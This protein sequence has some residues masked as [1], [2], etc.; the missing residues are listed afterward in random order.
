MNQVAVVTGSSRGIG[1]AIALQLA[2]DGFRVVV[3][4]NHNEEQAVEVLKT[5]ESAGG[6]GLVVRADVSN[7]AQA[8]ALIEK[9]V[10]EFGQVDVLVNN[11]GINKDALVLRMSDE[12]WNR[13]INTN[14]NS[15]FYCTRAVLKPMTRKRYGRIINISSVV[16]LY[17]N[18]G[19]AH[20]AA[21]KAGMLGFTFSVAQEYGS[22][23]ITAN[24]IAPG[25]IQTDLTEVLSAE[26]KTKIQARIPAN[27]L[28]NPDDV[29]YA[30]SFL[31]SSRAGYINAQV[32]RV[33]GGLTGI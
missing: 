25:F 27:R 31:A 18:A 21:A 12:D 20:Y 5:I 1:K 10:A 17:G 6:A 15:V 7:A 19:Q 8:Y 23:G 24:L 3:N 32:I 30:V 26:Q 11:A 33:D 14:L 28:G 22:R 13:V 4:Y 16:G 9:T 29:A 2:R